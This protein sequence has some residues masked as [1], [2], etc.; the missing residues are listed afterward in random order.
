MWRRPW[1][2]FVEHQSGVG[3]PWPQLT[4]LSNLIPVHGNTDHW[5]RW[6]QLSRTCPEQCLGHTVHSTAGVLKGDTH[7][8]TNHT[9]AMSQ[10]S[11]RNPRWVG[12]R[13]TVCS[14]RAGAQA[15]DHWGLCISYWATFAEQKPDMGKTTDNGQRSCVIY[16][17][18]KEDANCK[19]MVGPS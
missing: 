13:I 16:H 17:I 19:L 5:Q 1:Q 3:R 9:Y 15:K 11:P 14:Q 6:Q 7:L 10:K 18:G 4:G 12:W 8:S 2:T